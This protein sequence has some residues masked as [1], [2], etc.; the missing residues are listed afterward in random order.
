M[1][2]SWRSHPIVPFSRL[3]LDVL[4]SC[5]NYFTLI[6]LERKRRERKNSEKYW[7]YCWHLSQKI[8]KGKETVDQFSSKWYLK[9]ILLWI[10]VSQKRTIQEGDWEKGTIVFSL[11]AGEPVAV[12]HV[13]SISLTQISKKTNKVSEGTSNRNHCYIHSENLHLLVF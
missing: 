11:P 8:L 6:H 9:N 4:N 3:H 10:S 7:G 2:D 5:K 1:A 12:G 13:P